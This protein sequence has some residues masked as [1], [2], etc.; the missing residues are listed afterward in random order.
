MRTFVFT[1]FATGVITVLACGGSASV[2]G[3]DDACGQ[4]YDALTAY[5]KR[6]S[7]STLSG[8]RSDF[9]AI[10]KAA[11]AAPGTSIT[12]GML[13]NCASAVNGT[14]LCSLNDIAACKPGPGSLADGTACG[15]DAQCASGDCKTT[16]TNG[17][18][19]GTCVKTAKEGEA[20][21][22]APTNTACATDL[23]CDKNVC[24][25]N[26]TIPP[27]GT[28]SFTGSPGSNCAAGTACN[29]PP[30]PNATGTCAPIPKEGQPCTTTC[31][32]NL[33]CSNSVCIAR[34]DVGAACTTN[35]QCKNGLY[36][37]TTTKTC[38]TTKI[39]KVGEP[40]GTTGTKCD[41]GL[42]CTSNGTSSTCVALKRNGEACTANDR[43]AEF[44]NCINGV[45][46]INDPG[47]CK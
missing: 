2:T 36:C 5:A 12:Q 35:S 7:S 43:C 3:P 28:C 40:C 27:G 24:V 46:G 17:L 47:L 15:S 19:C 44:L 26:V 25:K 37:D 32:T 29:A 23:R 34:V 41:A 1:A 18:S 33:V 4:Y 42:A 45:C 9:L 22:V 10:C 31:D 39:A 21:N 30:T 38:A 13:A 16:T 8:E 20:C 11:L 14:T 6:C